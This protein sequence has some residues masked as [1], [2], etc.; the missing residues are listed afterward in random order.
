MYFRLINKK[1][2]IY[3]LIIILISIVLFYFFH[4]NKQWFHGDIENTIFIY[5][6]LHPYFDLPNPNLQYPGTFSYIINS[7]IFKIFINDFN[8]FSEI[9]DLEDPTIFLN[10][11][12]KVFI[13]IQ[14]FYY[15]SFLL[16]FFQIFKKILNDS[17]LSFLITLL[18]IFSSPFLYLVQ[19]L[20][21]ENDALFF[22]SLSFLF[23]IKFLEKD[24]SIYFFLFLFS[25]IVMLFIKVIFVFTLYLYIFL[26]LFFNYEKIKN[27]FCYKNF[28][29]TVFAVKLI[30]FFVL[31]LIQNYVAKSI[32]YSAI[33]FSTLTYGFVFGSIYYFLK[34]NKVDIKKFF[35]IS[36]ITVILI[37]LIISYFKASNVNIF[38]VLYPYE[39]LMNEHNK[40]AISGEYSWVVLFLSIM[41]KIII[42]ISNFKITFFE[43]VVL[44]SLPLL[45]IDKK[46]TL[47]LIILF[48]NYFL[49][50]LSFLV[51]YHHY[52]ETITFLILFF[53]FSS[54]A[55]NLKKFFVIKILVC[56]IIVNF[57][58]AFMYSSS[59]F[60]NSKNRID[61]K[62][63]N[64]KILNDFCM[65][66]N[67]TIE[68]FKNLDHNH[69]YSLYYT[70]KLFNQKMINKVCQ[71]ENS[72][73]K[74]L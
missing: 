48:F 31:F 1:D 41:K 44:L 21:I 69:E 19:I 71:I 56:F 58:N 62:I 3:S 37:L 35:L 52:Y 42:N 70:P 11:T 2:I 51:K 25:L 4:K 26:I 8:S 49:F 12:L 59:P 33:I 60:V 54:F 63:T 40:N 9:I 6:S 22:F 14:F 23:F 43:I 65:L 15:T 36:F 53:I 24:S 47:Y 17:E 73:M 18:L 45:K 64:S 68:Q 67:L 66:S 7:L 10:H 28:L 34:L 29:K 57:G 39:L 74:R 30:Y 5:N 16:I 61:N 38:Y 20:R 50:K 46:K 72:R 27:K 13:S 32:E 55:S